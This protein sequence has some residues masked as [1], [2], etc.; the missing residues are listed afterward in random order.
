MPDSGLEL[1]VLGSGRFGDTHLAKSIFYFARELSQR[2]RNKEEAAEPTKQTSN[3][4][5]KRKMENVPVE[6]REKSMN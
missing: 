1:R 5:E 4:Q 2:Y 6:L 3:R